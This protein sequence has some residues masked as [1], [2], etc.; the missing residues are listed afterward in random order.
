[1]QRLGAPDVV[2]DRVGVGGNRRRRHVA[3]PPV[4]GGEHLQA[5]EAAVQ[6]D[7]AVGGRRDGGHDVADERID[8]ARLDR[9]GIAFGRQT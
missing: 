5:G 8:L 2:D 4:V 9:V 7:D 1:M 3:V 6:D